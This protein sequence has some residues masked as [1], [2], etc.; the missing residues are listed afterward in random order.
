MTDDPPTGFPSNGVTYTRADAVLSPCG[1]Y[2]Y[3]LTRE[4][5]EEDRNPP[6]LLFVMLNPSVADGSADD[7]T[8]RKVV[9]F[10]HDRGYR[11]L[12]VAN[13]FAWRATDPA[14]LRATIKTL[15]AVVAVGPATDLTLRVLARNAD[16]VCVG[17]GAHGEKYPNRVLAVEQLLLEAHAPKPLLRLRLTKKGQPEH[18]LMIPY[19]TPMEVYKSP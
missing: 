9:R 2:R 10:A 16:A 5:T 19:G 18:P 12:R 7:H 11:A 6:Y 17:W 4:W 14:D 1:R 13:L 8:L 3:S 15:G